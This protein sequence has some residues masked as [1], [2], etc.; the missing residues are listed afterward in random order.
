[1]RYS[2]QIR[3]WQVAI[4][5]AALA[6]WEWGFL[7]KPTMPWLVP[8]ILDPYFVSKPSA[9]VA[10]FFRAGC[11]TDSQGLWLGFMTD[12]FKA[13]L[14][15]NDNNIWA[16]TLVTLQNTVIGF[17]VGVVTAVIAGLLLGRSQKLADVFEPF[18]V[19]VNSIPRIAL[20]PIIILAFGLGDLSKIVTAWMVVFFVVFFNTFEGARAVERDLIHTARLLGASNWAITRTV[21]IPST[22][23]WV[24]A[25]LSPAISFSLIG[26]IVGEFIG[27]QRGIGRIIIEAEAVGD[28]AGMMVAVFILMIVGVVLTSCIRQLQSYLLRWQP[29]YHELS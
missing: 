21:V 8:N 5:A 22:L 26:V 6:V 14:A 2:I 25:S 17:I 15:R 27:A 23:G 18:I 1:M 16:G 3:F 12:A 20:V 29:Q 28:A 13:C 24:F 11:L 10:R 19:A 4:L 9:I 7:L